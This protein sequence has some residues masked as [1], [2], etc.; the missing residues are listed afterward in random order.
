MAERIAELRPTDPAYRVALY[1]TREGCM[2]CARYDTEYRHDFE[3]TLGVDRVVYWDC[4][5]P[6]YRG[7]VQRANIN[8]LPAY[9]ILEKDQVRVVQVPGFADRRL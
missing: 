4:N 5:E 7:I 9:L 3:K 2:E 6:T 1:A 8:H